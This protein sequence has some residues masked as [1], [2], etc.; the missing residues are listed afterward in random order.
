MTKKKENIY[1]RPDFKEKSWFEKYSIEIF[2]III[3]LLAIH[4]FLFFDAFQG[5]KISSK[6]AGEFGSF[7]GGYLGTL[8]ALTSVVF[9]YTTLKIQRESSQ[10]E[11]FENKFFELIG[12][13]KENVQEII[14]KKQSGKKVFVL[15]IREFRSILEIVKDT[16]SENCTKTELINIAYLTF[17]YG[18]GPNST[19]ILKSYLTKYDNNKIDDLITALDNNKES[20]KKEKKFDFVPFEG[21][22]S[23]LGHY[24][25]HLFQTVSFVDNQ[26]IHIDKYEYIKI[27]RA[28]LSN[29]EQAL[30]ALNSISDIGTP[31]NDDNLMKIYRLIKNIPKNFFDNDKEIDL[32]QCFEG[33]IFEYQ[34]KQ[35]LATTNIAHTAIS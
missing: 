35:L 30:L 14:L 31:W 4:I 32:E 17:F 21:H 33:L 28:Q 10:I 8:F 29:H 6:N 16:F 22:Q 15:F 25:R 3:G 20:T 5:D 9:L 18:T 19:R 2:V 13:H 1:L 26:K 12:L 34:E 27:L 24:F 7:I 23:R 11:K